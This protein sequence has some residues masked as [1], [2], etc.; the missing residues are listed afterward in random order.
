MSRNPNQPQ[1][2]L[3]VLTREKHQ[4]MVKAMIKRQEQESK[5]NGIEIIVTSLAN[6][7]AEYPLAESWIKNELKGLATL[8]K[9]EGYTREDYMDAIHWIEGQ[10][11][12]KLLP[13]Q[14]IN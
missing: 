8:M 3:D 5:D 7:I 12:F 11:G 9:R 4:R 13:K 14:L 6:Q 10:V 2:K 1:K